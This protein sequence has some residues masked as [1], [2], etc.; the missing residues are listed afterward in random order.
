MYKVDNQSIDH[1]L[2]DMIQIL[3]VFQKK[4][5]RMDLGGV[6]GNMTRLHLA[7]MGTLSRDSMNV[8]ELAN[9]IMTTKPQ[10]THLIDQL[11][12]QGVVERLHDD[13]DRRVI[14]LSLTEKGQLLLSDI[15]KKVQANIKEALSDLT[16]DDL[17]AM[18]T[19]L[20]TLKNIGERLQA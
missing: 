10:I 5:L 3:P 17:K 16:T 8:T 15:R 7:I 9:N 20:E 1:I 4:L 2:E 19:A 13:R 12:A 11:V 18:Y 6:S 14:N